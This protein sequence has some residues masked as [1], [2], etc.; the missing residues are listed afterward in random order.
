MVYPQYDN[1]NDWPFGVAAKFIKKLTVKDADG[2][3]SWKNLD[4]NLPDPPEL[5]GDLEI[6]LF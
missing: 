6:R 5:P 2:T 4:K 1:S 3:N